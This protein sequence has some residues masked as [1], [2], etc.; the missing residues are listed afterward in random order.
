ML[1]LVL[2]LL[3]KRWITRRPH[4][5]VLGVPV[6]HSSIDR[7][8]SPSCARLVMQGTT[9]GYRGCSIPVSLP[10]ACMGQL[11]TGGVTTSRLKREPSEACK[12]GL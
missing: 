9:K 3:L 6:K 2:L 7:T 1:S 10:A 8:E 11:H 5:D 4:R 12:G